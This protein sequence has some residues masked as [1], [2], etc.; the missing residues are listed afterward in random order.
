MS[1]VEKKPLQIKLTPAQ[2]KALE[3]MKSATGKNFSEIIGDFAESYESSYIKR[4][5][6]Q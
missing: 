1:S 5:G 6:S 3:R 2:R 4:Y